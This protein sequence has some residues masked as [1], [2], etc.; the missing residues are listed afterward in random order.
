[1]GRVRAGDVRFREM[2]GRP[3]RL[4][5]VRSLAFGGGL[6]ANAGDLSL[7]NRQAFA[8]M[9]EWRVG[10]R[11]R[12]RPQS[13]HFAS[14][15]SRVF[16]RINGHIDG[17]THLNCTRGRH[18]I[19]TLRPSYGIVFAKRRSFVVRTF[20][21]GNWRR[22]RPQLEAGRRTR[23]TRASVWFTIACGRA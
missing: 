14:V 1:M 18:P 11:S 5:V 15:I 16:T 23:E 21:A 9:R 3:S 2:F 10:R 19:A 4:H 8:R 13:V 6:P 22:S 17:A 20:M 12:L 7:N